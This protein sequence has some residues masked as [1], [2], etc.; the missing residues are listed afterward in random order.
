MLDL[1]KLREREKGLL[2]RK[3]K[4]E[5][6]LARLRAREKQAARKDDTRRKIV[7]GGA[8]L[9]AMDSGA[10]AQEVGRKLVVRFV[11]DRDQKLFDGS[12]LAVSAAGA[13]SAPP[14]APDT[15]SRE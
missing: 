14:E 6:D 12:P 8:L 5:S 11:A 13:E 3:A 9:A 10:I 1:A 2:Q 15:A 7:L 4:L